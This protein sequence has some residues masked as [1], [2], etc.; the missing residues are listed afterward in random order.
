MNERGGR[1][2]RKSILFGASILSATS[3]CFGG[4]AFAQTAEPTEASQGRTVGDIVVTAQRREEALQD[5]PLAVTALNAE[6]IEDLNARDIRDLTGLVPN[7]VVSEISLGPGMTQVSLRGVNS[8]D[9]EKSFDPAIGVFIDGIYLGTSAFNL[10]DAFDLEQVEVLRGPQGTLFGRNTTGGAINAFRSRPTGEYGVRGVVTVGSDER[11][12]VQAVV[13][14]PVGD[15]MSLKFSGFS[16]QDDGLWDNPSGGATG[17]EDRWGVSARALFEFTPTF[18]LDVIVDYAEDSSELTPYVPR[19]VA[20]VTPLPYRIIGTPPVAATIVPGSPPDRYCLLPGGAC[21]QNDFSFTTT[22]DP[23]RNQS[24]MFALTVSSNWAL[25]PNFDLTTILGY[26]ES[27]EDVFIDFDGTARTVFNVVR[28]QEY[29]QFSGEV[30]LASNFEGPINFVA[31]AFYFT[32]E[33]ALRQAIKL[34]VAMVAPLPA[35]GLAFVA[36]SGD[37]D[38]HEAQTTA[39]FAQMDWDLSDQLTLTLGGRA[40]WDEK[41]VYTRFVGAPAGLNPFTYS[42][43]QGVPNNRP[44][45]SQGGASED[46]FEFTPRVALNYAVSDDLIV[47]GSYTRGY[48]AG[49]FSARAGTV[50]DVTTA[51]DP[52][53]I[54]AFEVGFKSDLFNRRARLNAAF[55]YN[56][57]KDKH[58]EAIEPGPP[59][60]FTSTTVRNVSGARIMG[61]EV[62]AAAILS[63]YFRVDASVG[64]MDSEYTD[65]TAFVSSGQYVSTPAQPPGTLLL[66][67]LSGLR[68]RRVPEITASVTPTFEAPIGAGFLTATS[69]IR[70]VDEQ[71][72]EFFNDPRG[73]IPAQ[74]YVDASVS[75][76]FG[77]PQ[78]D[79]LRV[80]LFGENLTENQEISSYVNSI[81]DFG[82]VAI[83]RTWGVELGFKF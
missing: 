3:L 70:Y 44:I 26:R 18:D 81:V 10:L 22:N 12:D 55:F 79:S 82:S 69:T 8:Q 24:D 40:S 7:L 38:E 2:S 43:A 1:M 11:R 68:L 27:E 66:A 35:L 80:T 46:W 5:V 47:Y 4:A 65:Y 49:G 58:E 39:L 28:E 14:V 41:T 20:T 61:L 71:V 31:G 45:T 50:A 51:F 6:M 52:E 54:N 83:P 23:H 9:P 30:R 76:A 21:A 17:A 57:Y 64:W 42:V 19:G 74:T 36:G 37:E 13:N 34:D 32:S 73:V 62:E 67:D 78:N 53:Y 59:P 75:Y 77:G 16:F 48:N 33:Y 25:N 56:D 63:D 72:A 60:T 29:E 15:V